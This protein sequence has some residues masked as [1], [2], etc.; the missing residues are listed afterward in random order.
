MQRCTAMIITNQV[1][2]GGK[3]T[4]KHLFVHVYIIDLCYAPTCIIAKKRK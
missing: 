3:F 4:E 2:A 1:S